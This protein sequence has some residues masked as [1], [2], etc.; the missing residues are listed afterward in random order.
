MGVLLRYYFYLNI[1]SYL[2]IEILFLSE[3]KL[4]YR[5]DLEFFIIIVFWV[6]L[7]RNNFLKRI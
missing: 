3:I 6:N 7:I 1:F 2:L 5:V 4:F